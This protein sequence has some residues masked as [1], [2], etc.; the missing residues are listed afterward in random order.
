MTL[1]NLLLRDYEDV[2]DMYYE[3]TKEV[4]PDRQVGERYFFYKE[5]MEWIANRNDVIIARK[6]DTIVGFSLGY[7]DENVG[8]TNPFYNSVI[9][10][11]KPKYRKTRAGYMLIKNV[12]SLAKELGLPLMANGLVSNGTS[13][14]IKKHFDCK[15]MFINFERNNV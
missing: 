13:N 5:V 3:F 6:D 4:Y 10:Y 14:M 8:L 7:M 11:V 9:Q 1:H 2:V 15:E 12:D